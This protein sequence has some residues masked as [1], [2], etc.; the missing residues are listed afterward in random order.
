MIM[1]ILSMLQSCRT[2]GIYS[3]KEREWKLIKLLFAFQAYGND[4]HRFIIRLLEGA[5]AI[6]DQ[7]R[8][9]DHDDDDPKKHSCCLLKRITWKLG[10]WLNEDVRAT[11][12]WTST[13]SQKHLPHKDVIVTLSFH[14]W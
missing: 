14:L 8:Y 10:K 7:V 4:V 3:Y 2:W 9:N 1:M 6:V 5:Q 12:Q 13:Y 11:P